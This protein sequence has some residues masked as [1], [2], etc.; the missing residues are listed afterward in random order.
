MTMSDEDTEFIRDVAVAQ[1]DP[2]TPYIDA[3]GEIYGQS[4]RILNSCCIQ[5]MNSILRV[6]EGEDARQLLDWERTL[7]R[8][9]ARI[10]Y[11]DL[12]VD[13]MAYHIWSASVGAVEQRTLD[14]VKQR[15]ADMFR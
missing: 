3:N 9:V 8:E 13:Q 15:V 11:H 14:A 1:L 12:C 10:N 6:R 7:Q 4:V 5:Y 2:A